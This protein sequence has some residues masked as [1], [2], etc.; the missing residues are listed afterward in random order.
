MGRASNSPEPDD[1]PARAVAR[2]EA[3][4]HPGQ[5]ALDREPGRLEG[6]GQELRRV[7]FLEAEL[8]VFP[9]PVGDLPK[10]LDR[11]GAAEPVEDVLLLLGD[12]HF[13]L[14]RLPRCR[15]GDEAEDEGDDD[16]GNGYLFHAATSGET[17]IQQ[18]Q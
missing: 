8:G 12:L 17:D 13:G 18:E 6:V 10:F 11:L 1:R 3:G 9:D 4:R 7:E 16:D 15:A 2:D 14:G 5:P